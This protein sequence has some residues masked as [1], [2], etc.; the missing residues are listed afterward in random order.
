MDTKF[1]A[2]DTHA[3]RRILSTYK[4]IA[5]VGVS[6]SPHRPSYFAAKYMQHHGYKI[7]PVNPRYK[8]VLGETC[9]ETLEAIPHAVDIV[10]CFR[11][12]DEIPALAAQAVAIKAKCLWLQ[13]SIENPEAEAYA[14]AEG[15]TVVANRCVKIEHARIFGGLGF[16]GVNTRVISSRRGYR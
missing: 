13:L 12:K 6:N 1:R 14:H 7:I 11:H 3:I 10:D 2:D 15:L 8:T 4:T 16:A 5:I 9:Y